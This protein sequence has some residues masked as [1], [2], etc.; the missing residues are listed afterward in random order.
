VFL[1]S[2]VL[3]SSAL[4]QHQKIRSSVNTFQVECDLG[5][6]PS[7][8]GLFRFVSSPVCPCLFVCLYVVL[9]NLSIFRRLPLSLHASSTSKVIDSKP[10]L[11]SRFV[12]YTSTLNTQDKNLTDT[13]WNL[14]TT[15]PIQT[16]FFSCFKRLPYTNNLIILVN[17]HKTKP[18]LKPPHH[19][20]Y[21]NLIHPPIHPNARQATQPS[22]VHTQPPF[23]SAREKSPSKALCI[24]SCP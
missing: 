21:Y 9:G 20:H 11:P 6:I 5:Q 16:F 1:D 15:K 17:P 7:I 22:S 13:H 2:S 4:I 10:S 23:S 12:L 14:W 19:P 18:R 3:P 24:Y 8:S